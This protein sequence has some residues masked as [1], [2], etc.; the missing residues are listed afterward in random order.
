MARPKD[1]RFD[2]YARHRIRQ[3]VFDTARDYPSWDAVSTDI[4]EK[5]GIDIPRTYFQRLRKDELGN[6]T[7]ETLVQWIELADPGFRETLRPEGIFSEVGSSSRDYYFHLHQMRDLDSWDEAL[8]QAFEGVYLCAP[9][10]DKNAYLPM[11]YVRRVILDKQ[12]I[13]KNFAG[14]RLNDW[15]LY[16]AKRSILI[17]KRT[18]RYH[19]WAAEIPITGLYPPQA[20]TNDITTY[21]EGVG[22]ASSNSMHVFLRDCLSRAPRLHSIL[23]KP[24]AGQNPFKTRAG[25]LYAPRFLKDLDAEIMMLSDD[26]VAHM[27]REFEWSLQSDVFL[28]G[29]TQTSIPPLAWAKPDVDIIYGVPRVYHRKPSGFL[30]DPETH[31]LHPDMRYGPQVA[32]IIANPLLIGDV[33]AGAH[34]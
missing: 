9:E 18:E 2:S 30:D 5:L 12:P 1:S 3:R 16:S 27:K 33:L 29:N 32:D 15:R 28:T 26:D 6:Q 10:D 8:L 4:A 11:S 21:Y 14:Q 24:K 7:L 25:E 17:L 13:P 31:L 34:S 20:N 23:I 22:I 19:F